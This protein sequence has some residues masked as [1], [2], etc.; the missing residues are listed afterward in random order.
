MTGDCLETVFSLMSSMTHVINF[1][2]TRKNQNYTK[3]QK[4]LGGKR[5]KVKKGPRGN[6]TEKRKRNIENEKKKSDG[7]TEGCGYVSGSGTSIFKSF[8]SGSRS[9]GSEG[10]ILP[11]MFKVIF[12]SV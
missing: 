10:R 3:A 2:E 1:S 7:E 8:G 11:K 4:Q 6:V 9:L 12:K 5:K